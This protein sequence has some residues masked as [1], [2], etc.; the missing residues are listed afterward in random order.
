MKNILKK[1]QKPTWPFRH[2]TTL[3]PHM[4]GVWCK[5][6][7]GEMKYFG[8]WRNPDP[9][10]VWATAA[11]KRYLNF[12]SAQQSGVV[13]AATGADV[14]LELVANHWLSEKESA[15]NRGEL[16]ARQYAAYKRLGTHILRTLDRSLSIAQLGPQELKR[17]RD[18]FTG[19]P[20]WVGSQIRWTRGMFNWGREYYAAMPRYG[21]MFSAPSRATVRKS[22]KA[23]DGFTRKELL[24][25]LKKSTPAVR[26]FILLGL[27]CGFG[28]TDCAELP[29]A[30]VDIKAKLIIFPR[31]KTGIERRCPLWPETVAAL[32]AYRRPNAAH[33]D[34][35]FVTRFGRPYVSI[36][37]H[38][39]DAGQVAKAT[40]TDCV[41]QE[42]MLAQRLASG[43]KNRYEAMKAGSDGFKGKGFYTLRHMFRSIAEETGKPSAIRCIMGHAAP[44][45]DEYYLHLKATG[46]RDL[47]IVTNCVR[48]WLFK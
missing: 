7:A 47:K 48:K 3:T 40:R 23:F 22:R 37:L 36:T 43:V 46:Y 16:S 28:Q 5:K 13:V 39:D 17:L 31:P 32:K 24:K 21:G 2:V 20:S 6:I 26:C 45:M 29:I 19:G 42:F 30:A 35:F 18:S 4:R 1:S 44:G 14:T 34:L 25:I 11:L 38:E 27:N 15:M 41:F 10:D 33:P 12:A 8:P 9:G